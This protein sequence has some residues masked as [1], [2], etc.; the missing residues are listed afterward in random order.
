MIKSTTTLMLFC[1]VLSSGC[2]SRGPQLTF[3]RSEGGGEV[4][5]PGSI[6]EVPPLLSP[7]SLFEGAGGGIAGSAQ[8]TLSGNISSSTLTVTKSNKYRMVGASLT[9]GAQKIVE[10]TEE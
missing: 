4:L 8:H 6:G 7:V 5:P 2:I 10:R 1:I 9:I 3:D